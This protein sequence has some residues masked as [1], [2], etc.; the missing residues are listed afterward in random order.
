MVY[1]GA[2]NSSLSKIDVTTRTILRQILGST[3]STPTEIL[4][5]D[6]GIETKKNRMHWL[7]A[8]YLIKLSHKPPHANYQQTQNTTKLPPRSTPNLTLLI[9]DLKTFNS[10]SR[11]FSADPDYSPQLKPP[12]PWATAP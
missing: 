8:R 9:E 10:P 3:R 11:L 12:P 1:G 5:S 7:A 2:S 4:Y 6:L